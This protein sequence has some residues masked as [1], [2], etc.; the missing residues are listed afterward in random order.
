VQALRDRWEDLCWCLLERYKRMFLLPSAA[1]LKIKSGKKATCESRTILGS[2]HNRVPPRSSHWARANCGM[3]W[4]TCHKI[5]FWRR[6]VSDELVWNLT[7]NE[8]FIICFYF[9]FPLLSGEW[10]LLPFSRIW[11]AH[12]TAWLPTRRGRTRGNRQF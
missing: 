11:Y 9:L 3:V 8:G 1:S 7:A 12:E 2:A 10:R 5:K 4:G 6:Q